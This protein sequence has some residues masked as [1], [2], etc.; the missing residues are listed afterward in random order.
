MINVEAVYLLYVPS[1]FGC[2][3]NSDYI[4]KHGPNLLFVNKSS[5]S[6]LWEKKS[7]SH[8]VFC[9][10]IHISFSFQKCQLISLWWIPIYMYNYQW[11]IC[12][13][14]LEHE[15]K[16]ALYGLYKAFRVNPFLHTLHMHS[17][18]GIYFMYRSIPIII[19]S[20]TTCLCT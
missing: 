11:I 5:E 19:T 13:T 6:Q 16:R 18:W 8:A 9:Y 10:E 20:Y 17:R 1:H 3:I 2:S 15:K 4:I 14:K 7:L 12:L